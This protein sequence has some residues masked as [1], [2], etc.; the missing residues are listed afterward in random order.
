MYPWYITADWW[1]GNLNNLS[2]TPAQR[3]SVMSYV[4]GPTTYDLITNF[5]AV[6][7]TGIVCHSNGIILIE[8]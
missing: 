5:S 8:E 2:C 1:L 3:N 4:V 7:D 6:A